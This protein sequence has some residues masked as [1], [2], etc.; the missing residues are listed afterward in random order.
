[1]FV[2]VL[3]P[4]ALFLLP[5]LPKKDERVGVRRRSG[6]RGRHFRRQLR[7][8]NPG[9]ACSPKLHLPLRHEVGERVG[10]RWCLGFRGRTHSLFRFPIKDQLPNENSLPQKF[11]LIHVRSWFLFFA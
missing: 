5:L 11:V 8:M 9:T 6:F 4:D 2:S 10:E 3:T 1:M 7:A